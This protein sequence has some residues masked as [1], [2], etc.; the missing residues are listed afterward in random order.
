[1]GSARFENKDST[2]YN[3]EGKVSGS[4]QK[5]SIPK[6]TTTVSW[7]GSGGTFSQSCRVRSSRPL[8]RLSPLS[9]FFDSDCISDSIS[10]FVFCFPGDF[11]VSSGG[12][13]FPDG[14]VVNNANYTISGGKATKK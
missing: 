6:G 7:N 5:M 3:L 8:L 4:S 13:S 14:K 10:L 9:V 12:V 11:I 2:A 1:M